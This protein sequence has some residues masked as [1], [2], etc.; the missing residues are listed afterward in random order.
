[1]LALGACV[2]G[3]P[4]ASPL[5]QPPT[6]VTSPSPPPCATPA[7]PVLASGVK[8]SFPV[9]E[10]ARGL[11]VPD[12]LLFDPADGT[13]L[14]GEHGSGRI[15]RIGG[16][17][18][19]VRLPQVVPEAEGIAQIGD[20]IYVA[21][22]L[23]SRVVVLTPTGVRTVI[24]LQP[25]ASGENL[26]GISTN[27]KV[28]GLVVPD[29][30]HGTVLFVSPSGVVTRRVRGFSRPAGAW[31]LVG[32]NGGPEY[33]IADENAA[34]IWTLGTTGGPTRLAGGLPGVDDAAMTD[35]SHIVVILPLAGRLR[36]ITARTDL[37]TGLRNPQ[38]LGFDG[39]QNVLLTESDAGRVDLV[40]RTF[41][42]VPPLATVQLAPG[43]TV[44]LSIVRARAYTQP[45]RVVQMTGGV[46]IA[47]PSEASIV[48]VQPQPCYS[49]AC[50]VTLALRSNDGIEYARF[51]YSD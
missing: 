18:S 37:A 47:D 17:V 8:S 24:Q 46:P 41:A 40:V 21:D 39:A 42:I 22:Q 9:L 2:P 32:S 5:A 51:A 34:A 14:V 29:S 48:E 19:L 20:T 7:V 23:H 50:H 43:Q 30:A 35:N 15:A 27:T 49:A 16:D 13:V 11:N 25:V 26:D 36:D 33:L 28:D 1:M 10:R 6:P 45:L 38:G 3:G 12:D 31:P 44:C 4:A